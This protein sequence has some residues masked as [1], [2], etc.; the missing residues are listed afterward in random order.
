MN[1][2]QPAADVAPLRVAVLGGGTVGGQVVRMLTEQGAD[3]A[4]RIGRPLQLIGVGVRDAARERPGIPREMLTSDLPGLIGARPDLVIELI[5][6]IEPAR[7]LI[8][9]ALASGASVISANKALIATHGSELHEAAEANGIDLFYEAAVAGAI[10]LL[11]PLRESLAGD[12]IRRVL[13]IV[14]GTTNYILT[15][16]EEEGHSFADS[17]LRAQALGY[18]E[19]DPTAD[20]EGLDAAAKA[21]I[22]AGLAFHTSVRLADVA[23]E[24]ITAVTPADMAA[25]RGLGYVIK[26]LAIADLLTEPEPG[27]CV[28][29]H[30][31]MVPRTHPLAGVRDAFNAVFIEAD[32]ADEVMFYG[33]GAGG[34]PTASAVLGDVVTAARNR[35]AGGVGPAHSSYTGLPVL[36]PST[37]WTAYAINLSV[38]DEP[39]VLAA[40]ASTFAAHGISIASVRQEQLLDADASLLV[41]THEAREGDLAA[42]VEALREHPA[43]QQVLGFMRVIGSRR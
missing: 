24:G 31:A 15:Q 43:V 34:A 36:P 25:A 10:P 41:L 42:T 35:I 17:L 23:V 16:M 30:P 27:V 32:A 5:G 26:L 12:Q 4:A 20:V 8:L 6:G 33:R 21:A 19:A 18:A 11:R 7:Q 3:L 2:P 40:V 13:G 1:P 29:V 38:R 39:G 14:N 28:R 9:A 22:L 37:A